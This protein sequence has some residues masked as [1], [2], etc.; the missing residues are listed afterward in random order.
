MLMIGCNCLLIILFRF[1]YFSRNKVGDMKEIGI[2]DRDFMEV[3]V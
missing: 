3:M 2:L 1:L